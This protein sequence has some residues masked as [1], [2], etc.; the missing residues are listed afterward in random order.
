[1]AFPP[2][3]NCVLGVALIEIKFKSTLAPSKFVI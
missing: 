1:M 2:N 3:F